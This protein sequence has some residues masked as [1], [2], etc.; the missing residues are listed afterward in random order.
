M[1][2]PTWRFTHVATFKLDVLPVTPP[3]YTIVLG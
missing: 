2:V 1:A 3:T